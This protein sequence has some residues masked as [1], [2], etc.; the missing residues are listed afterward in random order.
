V[1]IAAPGPA[2]GRGGRSTVSGGGCQSRSAAHAAAFGLQLAM[3]RTP[4][5]AT[6]R[7]GPETREGWPV[8]KHVWLCELMCLSKEHDF[9]PSTIVGCKI[10]LLRQFTAGLFTGKQPTY[11]APSGAE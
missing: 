1:S 8:D 7:G 10:K 3:I 9:N 5:A 2:V 6:E 11:R 4:S